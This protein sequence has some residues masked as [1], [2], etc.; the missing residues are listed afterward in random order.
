M[1]INEMKEIISIWE[2]IFRFYLYFV[3]NQSKWFSMRKSYANN[4]TSYVI[5]YYFAFTAYIKSM[6]NFRVVWEC[7]H[8]SYSF[9]LHLMI[10]LQWIVYVYFF[11]FFIFCLSSI[12][13]ASQKIQTK[14]MDEKCLSFILL[15]LRL[16]SH[17]HCLLIA[18]N[19]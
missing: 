5:C 6:N 8:H 2:M 11:F 16:H 15:F 17:L 18:L 7:F 10:Y 14:C 4:V 12:K 1:T 13:K 19:V 9:I 3:S